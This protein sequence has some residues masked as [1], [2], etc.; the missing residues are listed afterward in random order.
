MY[1]KYFDSYLS[2]DVEKVATLLDE[3]YTQIGS[4]ESEVFCSKKDAV[5]IAVNDNS[6]GIPQKVLDKIFQ[7]FFTTKPTGPGNRSWIIAGL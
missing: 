4:A 1:G 5:E 3:E 2:G 6:N 7:P